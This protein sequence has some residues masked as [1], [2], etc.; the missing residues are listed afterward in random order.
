MMMYAAIHQP[1][2]FPWLGFFHKLAMSDVFVILDDAQH[3]KTGGNWSNRSRLMLGGAPRWVTG[4]IQRPAHG[5]I[6]LNQVRWIEQPWQERML[7]SLATNYQRA[8][9][10]Q[11]SMVLLRP[12]IVNSEQSLVAYNLY[13]IGL[14][15]TALGLRWAPVLSS[16][17][18]LSTVST[19]RLIDVVK[20][21]G[22]AGYL[23]GG[24]AAGY[25]DDALFTQAGIKL[26]CQSF[27]HLIYP[28]VGSSAFVPGLSIIDALMNC[29]ISRTRQ[30][31]ST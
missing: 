21:V 3:T 14:I 27:T 6:K 12:A 15:A 22:C 1:N 7:K 25:Q 16:S 23:V 2:F 10:Y 13:A 5:T 17:L 19:Q 30:L 24:G 18:A 28:Q 31:V 4:P 8:P 11:E 26:K 29:G 20:A 9:F